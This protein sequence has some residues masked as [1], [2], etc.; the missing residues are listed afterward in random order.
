MAGS[1]ARHDDEPM[2]E[3]NVTPLVDVMLVLLVI[4][5]ILAPMFSQALRVDLP[6]ANASHSTDPVV[7]DVTVTE[8]GEMFL[9]GAALE[10]LAFTTRLRN[11]LTEQPELVARLHADGAARYERVAQ[12]MALIKDAGVSRVAFATQTPGAN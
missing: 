8:S 1:V 2:S 10:E 9:D 11:R 4:F 7:I 3:I 12:V 5:I 6:R